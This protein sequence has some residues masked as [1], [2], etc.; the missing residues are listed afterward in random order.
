MHWRPISLLLKNKPDPSSEYYEPV[1]ATH[2]MLRVMEAV[3]AGEGDEPIGKLY[4]ELGSRV[5]H[6]KDRDFAMADAL[7]AVGLD[8]R[9]AAAYDDES[10]DDVVRK[11]HDDGLSLVGEDVGT[12][13]IAIPDG[14]GGRVGIF[15]PVI[16]RVP[17]G[18]KALQLW[19]GMVACM[20]VPGFWELKKT[21]TERP[22]L[23][24]RPT[25]NP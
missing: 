22:D 18:D 2:K 5:H 16:T 23:G 20:Q 3:R 9:Y 21:R 8:E 24:D 25:S 19:D 7:R 1:L 15:G 13:I 4:W 12:P 10:W 14:E 11:G 6:D 17:D